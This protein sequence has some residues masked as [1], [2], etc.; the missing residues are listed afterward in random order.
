MIQKLINK[1][2]GRWFWFHIRVS[3]MKNGN[4]I[5]FRIMQV[6]LPEK[7]IILSRRYI[8]KFVHNDN[9]VYKNKR[10]HGCNIEIVD[11][12]YLGYFKKQ[13]GLS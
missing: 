13:K 11:I 9:Q 12:S 4:E 8:S 2:T 10:T 5:G 7:S 6:G 1:I 3:Y